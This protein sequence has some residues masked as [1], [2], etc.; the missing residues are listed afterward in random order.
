MKRA[1]IL[2]CSHAAGTDIDNGIA[3]SYP[4]KIAERLGYIA[5]NYAIAGGSNDAMFRIYE[6]H[7]L[8]L[9]DSDMVIA[10]WSGYNRTEIWND[11]NTEWQALAPGK[12]DIS[13]KE[14]LDYQQ[15]W[16]TYHTDYRV[17][18]LNK[19]KNILALNT[20]AQQ[21]NVPVIN[22]DSFWPVA[23]FV[24]PDFVNWPIDNNFWDWCNTK[25]YPRTDWGHFFEPAHQ[26]F[27]EIVIKSIKMR[28]TN[29]K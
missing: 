5:E 28:L 17:G 27:A 7:H 11:K 20:L 14:Y 4:V 15:Q 26:E 3:Y 23:D 8:T 19:I 21:Q 13:P 6:K 2:G 24:W 29:D 16:V 1:L 25:N 10:C 9:D 22:I 18:R 12:T